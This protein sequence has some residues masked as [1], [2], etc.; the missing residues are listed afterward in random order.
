[1]SIEYML[2]SYII[3]NLTAH[4]LT[5]VRALCTGKWHHTEVPARVCFRDDHTVTVTYVRAIPSCLWVMYLLMDN[6]T[7]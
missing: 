3:M 7:E 1:M 2:L 5:Y 6:S 4:H